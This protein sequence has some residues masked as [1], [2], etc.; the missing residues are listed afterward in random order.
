MKSTFDFANKGVLEQRPRL[1][2]ACLQLR[3]M[4]LDLGPGTK[5]PTMLELRSQLG[6]SLRTI[7]D[8]V[9]FLENQQILKSINGVGIYVVNPGQAKTTTKLGLIFHVRSMNDPYLVSLLAGVRREAAKHDLE[10]I[11]L[12]EQNDTIE[13][14]KVDAVLMYCHVTEALL[15]NL[16]PELP[17]VLLFQHFPDFTCV[18]ADDFEGARLA[19]QHLLELGHQRIAC[20]FSSGSDTISRQRLAGYRAAHEEAKVAVHAELEHYLH[21]TGVQSYREAGEEVMSAWLENGWRELGC[22][23][24]LAHNDHT[25]IGV[26]KV[27]TDASIRVPQDVSVTGFDGTEISD[28]CT[29]RLTT[30]KVPLAEIGARAVKVLLRQMREGVLSTEKVLLPVS[31]E[32]GESTMQF[33]HR[34]SLSEQMAENTKE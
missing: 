23:A 14:G 28:L 3:E 27:L 11:L 19:T 31:F 4:A 10:I 32:M 2:S 17:Q 33:D 13:K 12:D 20:L 30:I 18:S 7:N 34:A 22:T 16:P 29:P 25:A 6:M 15:M 26:M 5:L 9:R 8:A 1:K 24:M 21:K